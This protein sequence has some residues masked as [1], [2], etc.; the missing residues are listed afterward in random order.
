MRVACVLVT[1]ALCYPLRI[2][3]L[4]PTGSSWSPTAALA[5]QRSI[6]SLQT[7]FDNEKTLLEHAWERPWFGWGRY[8]R[9]RVFNGWR[10][11]DSSITDGFW[12]IVLGSFGIVGF[13]GHFGLFAFAVYRGASALKLA[14]SQN[15]AIYLAA[16][17]LIIA[18]HAIDFLPN[19]S[20]SPWFWLLLGA[21]Y[22][23]VEQLRAA[24]RQGCLPSAQGS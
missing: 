3:D 22:G 23:R 13:V 9:N 19:A 10:G 14:Q 17:A 16:L 7:R 5:E 6:R 1:V 24:S 11:A 20:N 8:G 21:M 15:D 18:V 2:V 4:V 12:I